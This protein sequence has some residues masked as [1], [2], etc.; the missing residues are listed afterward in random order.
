M[1]KLDSNACAV[2]IDQMIDAYE[3]YKDVS[4]EKAG[5]LINDLF[6][7]G[8]AGKK[9]N[10]FQKLNEFIING[11]LS[12]LG[13]PVVNTIGGGLQ[14]FAKPLLNAINAYVPK[15]GQNAAEALRERR[16]AKAMVSA[17]TDGWVSDT[18]FLSRGFGTGLPV[19]FKLTPKALGLS[20]KQF[21]QLMVDLGASPDVDGKVNPELAR[22]VLGESYDYMTHAIGGKF[23]DIIRIPT[24]LTVGIDE[25]FKARLRSQRM[26]GY[27]SRKASMDEEKGL[28]SYDDLY[29]KYKEETFSTGKAQD[30]YGD[31]DRFE[32]VVGGDFDT[33]IYDVRNYAVDGTF[34]AKLSGTLKKISEAKGEGRTPWETLV[35]Q[36]IPFL[37]TPWNIFKESG[38]YI[39]GVG[40][41]IR[42]TKTVTNKVYKR[43]SDTPTFET[44]TVNMPKE[45]MVARQLV[46]FGI[47]TGV[48]QMFEQGLITGSMPTEAAER[49][50][51]Q[52]QGKQP[53]SIKIGGKWVDY[54]RA[55][56]FATVLGMMTD[57]FQFTKHVMDGKVRDKEEVEFVLNAAW[58]S[59]KS[60]M[61]QKTFMQGFADL[62]TPL[63]ANDTKGVETLIDNYAK[64]LIPAIS[65]TAARL[66]DQYE[67]EAIT[68]IEKLQQR[69]PYV[70]NFLPERYASLSADPENIQPMM[71]NLTQASTGIATSPEQT[72]FQKR[73]S[74]LGITIAPTKR[75]MGKVDL[76]TE[77]FSEYKRL[78]NEE[79]TKLLSRALP[80]LERMPNKKMAE[81]V[82]EKQIM[83]RAR[84]IAQMKLLQK[85]PDLRQ[86]IMAERRYERFGE[87]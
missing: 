33:A 20:E 32:Q 66:G 77:Q 56:P 43:G 72:P 70:R 39:P 57:T 51:W 79:S 80:S 37:R 27:L 40:M 17:L 83:A 23:G 29:K 48:Y 73:V 45:E 47:T 6:E 34:Q 49:N 38:G 60:N 59:I 21:N 63:F 25:Y 54:S 2:D 19:D 14:T 46:G 85:Y 86:A 11:M 22:Q 13:T 81:Y 78:L 42:P 76:K 8:L 65:N 10:L 7:Q 82:V 52:A 64:R 30:L 84:K 31:M 12:G 4:P 3:K 55:E 36:T 24:R 15:A 74:E 41:F 62:V 75:S 69:I 71:R 50:T 68:T 26:M 53:T 28:G 5:E 67:R 87:E 9:P 44:I 61:L 18:I 16:A 58:S 1:A 35:T